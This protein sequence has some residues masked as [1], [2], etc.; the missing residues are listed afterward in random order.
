MIRRTDPMI[1]GLLNLYIIGRCFVIGVLDVESIST[2]F[3]YRRIIPETD[4][5]DNSIISCKEIVTLR[6]A[7]NLIRALVIQLYQI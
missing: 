1:Y 4:F 5:V 7:P 6:F 2:R 3:P